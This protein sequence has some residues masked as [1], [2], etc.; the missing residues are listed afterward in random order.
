MAKHLIGPL[1]RNGD[2]RLQKDE[3]PASPPA[4]AGSPATPAASRASALAAVL[5]EK[6]ADIDRNGDGEISADELAQRLA[7]YAKTHPF[8]METGD[9]AGQPSAAGGGP[10]PA[11]AASSAPF[12]IS[13]KRLPPDLPKWFLQRDAD[14]DGQ[15]SLLEYS[16]RATA[17]DVAAF[18]PLDLNGDGLLT[19]QEY[20]A[21][22]KPPGKKTAKEEKP[23]ETKSKRR[24]RSR[25]KDSEAKT[26]AAAAAKTE[27]KTEASK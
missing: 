22:T 8:R 21:A 9:P 17:A 13:K 3:C 1:D 12:A 5:V 6:W 2:G 24:S 11:G 16:P 15:L 4:S 7:A 27:A 20:L 19:P 25:S 10:A 26:D 23:D 14:G 18:R